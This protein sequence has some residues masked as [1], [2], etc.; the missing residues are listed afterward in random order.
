MAVYLPPCR[1]DLHKW[2]EWTGSDWEK[3]RQVV[4]TGFRMLSPRQSVYTMAAN[5][6]LA[7]INERGSHGRP[8]LHLVS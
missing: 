3:I 1:V 5:A 7:W 2:C 6:C 4:G 8:K